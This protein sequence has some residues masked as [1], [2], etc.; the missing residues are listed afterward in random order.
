MSQFDVKFLSDSR[1]ESA[2]EMNY[3]LLINKYII[4]INESINE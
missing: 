4:L 3:D 1:K 2:V